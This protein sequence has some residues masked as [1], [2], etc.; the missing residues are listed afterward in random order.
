MTS[1]P[2][3]AENAKYYRDSFRR[4]RDYSILALAIAYLLQVIDANVFAYM[5]DFELTDDISMKVQP[6]VQPLDSYA[7]APPAV[8]LSVG[9]KF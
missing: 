8:G 9:L 4:Y 2:Q 6:S 7:M 5:Q 3:S 1:P